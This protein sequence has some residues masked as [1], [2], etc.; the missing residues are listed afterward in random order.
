MLSAAG[1]FVRKAGGFPQM[2][3]GRFWRVMQIPGMEWAIQS[4]TNRDCEEMMQACSYGHLQAGTRAG[5]EQITSVS[6]RFRGESG[7]A[8]TAGILLPAKT[9]SG[10]A[11]AGTAR[12]LP[13]T[14]A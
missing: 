12:P 4:G 8:G 3:N 10:G 13:G 7:S 11:V 9:A 6:P 2:K 1:P 5:M 14:G